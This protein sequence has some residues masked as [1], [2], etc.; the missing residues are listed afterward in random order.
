MQGSLPT[1]PELLDWLA[2]DFIESG[3][4]IKRLNK[5]IVMSSTF[6]QS[7]YIPP[8]LVKKD[9]NNLLLARGPRTRMS[10]EEVRD[11]AL[12]VSGLLVKKLGGPSVYPYQPEG[13]WGRGVTFYNYP[14]P[15]SISAE[16]QHRRSLYTFVKRNTPPPSLSV[17]DFSERH[18]TSVRRQVSNTPLQALVLLND[19][20]YVEAYRSMAARALKTSADEDVQV[21]LIFRLAAKRLPSDGELAALREFYKSEAARFTGDKKQAVDLVHLGV[22][23]VDPALDVIQ[24]AALTN[25]ASA[26]MNSPEAYTIH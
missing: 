8:D 3:W 13:V 19:P 6:Q 2:V 25:V 5:M 16:E 26:V 21:R 7:C 20:Q 11:N 24:L 10:A 18:A 12:A 23:P 15:E 17:F 1:H 4:D 22:A 14:T 9:P